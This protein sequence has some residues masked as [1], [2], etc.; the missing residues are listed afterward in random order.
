MSTT[1]STTDATPSAQVQSRVEND[2]SRVEN[3]DKSN[4]DFYKNTLVSSKNLACI[5]W[6]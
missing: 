3:D 2:K 1:S 6:Y 4:S 5:E